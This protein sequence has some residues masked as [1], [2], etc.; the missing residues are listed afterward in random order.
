MLSDLKIEIDHLDKK[1]AESEKIHSETS[2]EIGRGIE[3]SIVINWQPR[4]R[5]VSIF[6]FI[7]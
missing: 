6:L 5:F 3:E 7:N 1:I 4:L 2:R